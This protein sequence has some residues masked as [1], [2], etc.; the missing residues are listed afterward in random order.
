[1]LRSSQSVVN[2][3]NSTVDKLNCAAEALRGGR[4]DLADTALA[5]ARNAVVDVEIKDLDGRTSSPEAVRLRDMASSLRAL[6]ASVIEAAGALF[7]SARSGG[8]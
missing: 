3:L 7:D 8:T 1:M 4:F 6:Q 2:V 5:E